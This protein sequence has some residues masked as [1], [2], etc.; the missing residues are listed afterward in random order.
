[1]VAIDLMLRHGD[2]AHTV[3]ALAEEYGEPPTAAFDLAT[4]VHRGGGLTKDYLYL[5]GLREIY[6]LWRE[7]SLE[8]LF[9]GKT[10]LAWLGL[11]DELRARKLVEPPAHVP[12]IFTE[13]VTPDPVVEFVIRSIQA[14]R[15][16]VG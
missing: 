10:S 12:A 9:I 14:P 6:A 3:Q 1:M 7:R 15:R 5:R 4:R 2:F 16:T 13:P 8:N 11:I